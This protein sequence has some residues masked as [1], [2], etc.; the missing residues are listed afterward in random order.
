MDP[1]YK[2]V[3]PRKEVR[4]G[5]SFNPDEFA[6]ALEQIV[7]GTAPNDYKDPKQ[8]F[9][10][11][12]FTQA[13]IEHSGM[14]LRRLSGNTKNTAP[15]LTLVTQFGG[16]K[17]HTLTALYHLTNNGDAAKKFDGIPALLKE[18]GL[19]KVP[20]AKVGVF[21][22]SAWDPQKGAETPWI[23]LARQLAGDKGVELL[24]KEKLL[25]PPGT[26]AIA[27]IIEAAG[28]TVLILFDEVLNFVNRHRKMADQLHA[29]IQNLTVAIKGTSN[30]AAV[31]SLPRSQVEMTEWDMEWQQ[32]ITKVVK[33]VSK[34]LFVADEE[35]VSEVI[36]R[37]LFEDIGSEAHRKKV[38]KAYA[39]WCFDRRAS[40][41]PEW[42]AVDTATSDAKA[43]EFLQNRFEACYPF[44]PATLSVFQR[45]W[46]T[47]T[48]FQQ[49]RGTLAMLAQWISLT[50]QEGF[51]SARKEPLITLGS[52]PL[53]ERHFIGIVLDSIGE[54]RLS[55]AIKTDIAGSH[56]H[57][58]ALDADTKDNLLDIHRRVGSSIFFESS[59]GQV[60][61]IATL[62]ELRYALGEPKMDTT[63]I[64]NAAHALESKAF[65]LSKVGTDGFRVYHKATIRKAV[66]DKKASLDEETDIW[67][68]TLDLIKQEFNRSKETQL[69]YF[70]ENGQEVPDSPRLTLAVMDPTFEWSTSIDL[71]KAL[72]EWT[73][74]RGSSSRL[75]PAALVW[76]FK[77][78]GRGIRDKVEN[79]LAWQRVQSEVK[80]GLLGSDYDK[81]DKAE[82]AARVKE[83]EVSAIDEVW[84][85]YRYVIVSDPTTD[86]RLLEMAIDLG[87]GHSSSGESLTG[88]IVTAL[89][90]NGL[91]NETVG[92][93]YIGRKWPEALKESGAW[94]LSGLRQSFLNGTLTRL[95]D[96]DG[97]LKAR[98]PDFVLRGDF[99][100]ASGHQKDGSY[101]QVYFNE[102]IASDD[103]E[104]DSDV[105]LLTAEKAKQLTSEPTP[106]PV[107]KPG[108]EPIPTPTPT[109]DGDKEGKTPS[110][111]PVSEG[112]V[113]LT[114]GG[115]IPPE[116]WN[117]LGTRLI[118]KLR[119]GMSLKVGVD[120]TVTVRSKQ[121]SVLQ[122]EL[123]QALDDLGL[124]GQVKIKKEG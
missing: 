109:P 1:W 93:G 6:I 99:G 83:A 61:K 64:D 73:F 45:K 116:S 28:G 90:S 96:P 55:A 108:P 118:P 14:V 105:F 29:F 87:A 75:Y 124:G 42:T 89:K 43:K 48:Q 9:S 119:S 120:F 88:R 74:K 46:Q 72:I 17:T 65:F 94:P 54:S 56:S 112:K 25:S 103:V 104:F 49:T 8:F 11:N 98:I 3:T 15:V 47:L 111:K 52:G 123:Q 16:G 67:P 37:R 70:P 31:I 117:R 63:S 84:S 32:K 24:G 91:L 57:A 39:N 68:V 82:I 41:P 50:Y 80:Q 21:V 58:K 19:K 35:E 95:T 10:R 100:L 113:T 110:P 38:A 53:H 7:S 76:C 59:G 92:P 122:S 30:C 114:I 97:V 121:A 86:D 60:E 102:M 2:V 106:V 62:P 40:L 18:A 13:L 77:K 115:P 79:W 27:N 5:R 78:P 81:A 23:D 66:A 69:C 20:K 26:E 85:E 22:G 71:R 101:K 44:H 36:R 4:E 12:Y 34:G 33:R 107:P 51:K